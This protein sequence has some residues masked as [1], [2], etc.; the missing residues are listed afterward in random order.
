MWCFLG[1]L[2]ANIGF[3][4]P[5]SVLQKAIWLGVLVLIAYSVCLHIMGALYGDKKWDADYFKG[6]PGRL[7][8]WKNSQVTWTLID[9]HYDPNNNW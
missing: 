7:M 3:S 4:N 2:A 6:Q 9:I 1:I 5:L 8:H